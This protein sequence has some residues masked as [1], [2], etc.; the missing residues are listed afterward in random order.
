MTDQGAFAFGGE[1]PEGTSRTRKPLPGGYEF[2]E[3]AS[4]F[5]KSCR[6]GEEEA[7]CY[8]G[9]ILY[10]ASSRYA[11]RRVLVT[12]TEDVGLAAPEVITRVA[13]LV[14]AYHQAKEGAYYV[15]PNVFVMAVLLVARAP[16][17]C[18]VDDLKNLTL[19]RIKR[20]KK[21]QARPRPIEPYHVDCHTEAGKAAGKTVVDWYADRHGACG[22]PPN[23]YTEMLWTECPEFRPAQAPSID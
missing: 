1:D 6:R 9:L 3:V 11:W 8:W 23:R 14:Q 17:S 7:A 2:S 21:G 19:A 20:V 22:V 4:A 5:Q 16:K 10:G 12:A 18:E 15:D 13:A